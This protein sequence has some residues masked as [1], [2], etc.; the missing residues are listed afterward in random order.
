M[1]ASISNNFIFIFFIIVK[2]YR[3]VK[4]PETE[5][6]ESIRRFIYSEITSLHFFD[7]SGIAPICVTDSIRAVWTRRLSAAKTV[8]EQHLFA[9]C[10]HG[11]KNIFHNCVNEK[12]EKTYK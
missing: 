5:I 6:A 2:N 11:P 7:R 12:F 9:K 3:K 8:S 10:E 1:D 4:K